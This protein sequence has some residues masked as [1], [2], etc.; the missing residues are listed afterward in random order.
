MKVHNSRKNITDL[1]FLDI[2]M[3][4]SYIMGPKEFTMD[5][6]FGAAGMLHVSVRV[7]VCIHV[8]LDA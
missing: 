3:Q 5:D 6:C 1:F 4:K 2:S 7:L 8:C